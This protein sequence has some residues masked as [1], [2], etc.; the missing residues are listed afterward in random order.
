[1]T[2]PTVTKPGTRLAAGSCPASGPLSWGRRLNGG[3]GWCV[4]GED[5]S[6]DHGYPP[7]WQRQRYKIGGLDSPDMCLQGRRPGPEEAINLLSISDGRAS[8]PTAEAQTGPLLAANQ[9][10]LTGKWPT[11]SLGINYRETLPE[12]GQGHGDSLAPCA[13]KVT[14]AMQINSK[15]SIT[16]L[17]MFYKLVKCSCALSILTTP[18]GGP[19]HPGKVQQEGTFP[20][21]LHP[22]P[23]FL[24]TWPRFFLFYQLLFMESLFRCEGKKAAQ[25]SL[26]KRA[27][28]GS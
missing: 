19:G 18:G 3:P 27:K 14:S 2:L 25:E 21:P 8:L 16:R 4:A 22:G 24:E 7:Q 20:I 1:M 15:E 13:E 9:Q 5:T 17:T 28:S 26:R 23:P 12:R 6:R 10:F 11:G